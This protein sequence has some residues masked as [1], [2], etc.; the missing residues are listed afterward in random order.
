VWR[1][2]QCL[3][4]QGAKVVLNGEGYTGPGGAIQHY[5]SFP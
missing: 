2:V 3:P 4:A 1:I 5:F